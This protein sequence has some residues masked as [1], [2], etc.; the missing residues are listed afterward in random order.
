MDITQVSMKEYSESESMKPADRR[1]RSA[2]V[3]SRNQLV[4]KQPSS[5]HCDHEKRYLQLL[6]KSDSLVKKLGVI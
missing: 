1:S 6:D 4:V 3:Q 5:F 2:Y